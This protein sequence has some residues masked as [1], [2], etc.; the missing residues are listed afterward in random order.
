MDREFAESIIA[1]KGDDHGGYK[2]AK[3]RANLILKNHRAVR[4]ILTEMREC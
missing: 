3:D 4:G 1:A 2:V